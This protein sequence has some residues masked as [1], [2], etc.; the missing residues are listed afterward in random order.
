[1][2]HSLLQLCTTVTR[3]PLRWTSAARRSGMQST[4]AV[5]QSSI[6]AG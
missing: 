5:Q 6:T 3:S 1:M 4:I 2:S